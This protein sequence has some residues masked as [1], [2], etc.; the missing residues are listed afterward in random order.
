MKNGI[1]VAHLEQ[2]V[3]EVRPV[4]KP[5]TWVKR[6]LKVLLI[7]SVSLVALYFVA[8]LAW[9]FSGSNEW[10]LVQD[11]NGVKIYALK[12]PGS[13]LTKVKGVTRVR[14]TLSGLLV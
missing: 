10:K 7:M 12:A 8:S 13:D 1:S 4:A 2:S 3:G 9:R 14:S 11:E 5:K 6:L